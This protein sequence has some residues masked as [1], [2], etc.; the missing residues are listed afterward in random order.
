MTFISRWSCCTIK[1]TFFT[2]YKG[3]VHRL[4]RGEARRY[5]FT[6]ELSVN[7]ASSSLHHSSNNAV[8]YADRIHPIHHHGVAMATGL[9]LF[10]WRWVAL[11]CWIVAFLCV[12]SHRRHESAAA[13]VNEQLS[14]PWTRSR[15][16]PLL[17]SREGG[18]SKREGGEQ[19]ERGI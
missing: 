12:V 3:K 15:A 2:S 16:R 4:Q 11:L 13:T 7:T 10:S 8:L 6:H 17:H 14:Y 1:D 5:I 19:R 18:M 9:H